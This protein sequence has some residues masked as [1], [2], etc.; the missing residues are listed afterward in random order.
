M[1]RAG[2]NEAQELKKPPRDRSQSKVPI[3]DRNSF[4]QEKDVEATESIPFLE[5]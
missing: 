3:P 1:L 2:H 5:M 4:I